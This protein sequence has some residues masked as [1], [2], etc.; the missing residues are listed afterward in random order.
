MMTIEEFN[1]LDAETAKQELQRC[2]GATRWVE[3]MEARRPFGSSKALNEM[4]TEIWDGLSREDWLEAFSH[5]P[6]IGGVDYLR[7]KFATTQDWSSQEQAGAQGASEKVLHELAQGN[8]TYE[9]R[10]GY[11][12]IVCA[13]GKTAPE[14]LEIL[15][16]RLNNA[17]DDELEIARQEQNKI[18]HL[19]I[20]KML[21]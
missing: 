2:C 16:S 8:E 20:A 10:F 6:K 14:M 4:A 17:P 18:T 3:Q 9:I 7:K 12:F 11:I 15:Q 1:Q 13:T 21:S 5:H 19:R